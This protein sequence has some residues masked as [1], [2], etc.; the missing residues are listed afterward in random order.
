MDGGADA[1][2][3][4]GSDI[5]TWVEAEQAWKLV[6]VVDVSGKTKPCRWDEVANVCG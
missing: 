3:V 6:G 1:F 2:F 4:E 5:T